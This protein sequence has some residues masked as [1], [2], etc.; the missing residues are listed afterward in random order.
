[1]ICTTLPNGYVAT[2]IPGYFW[3]INDQKLYSIKS[4]ILREMILSVPNRFNG[5]S[6]PAYRVSFE[7]K[8][9]YITLEELIRLEPTPSVIPVDKSSPAERRQQ[10]LHK[11]Y[12]KAMDQAKDAQWAKRAK[13]LISRGWPTD[14]QL[15]LC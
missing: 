13:Q 9:R 1:M 12:T 11:R 15:P 5:M 6:L 10:M 8:K 3:S 2:R 7:G 14:N 4:G